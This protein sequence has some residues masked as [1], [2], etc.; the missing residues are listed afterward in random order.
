MERVNI[1]GGNLHMTN[2]I[3][4]KDVIILKLKKRKGPHPLSLK[5]IFLEEPEGECQTE[6][7]SL[8]RIKTL[9]YI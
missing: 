3:F 2:G 8:L 6:F 1:D 4:W 5:N 9:I 7:P